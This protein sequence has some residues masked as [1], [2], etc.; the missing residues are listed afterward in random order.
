M[1]RQ[2]DYDKMTDRAEVEAEA[3]CHAEEAGVAVW[4]IA[5]P[6]G[7]W[8]YSDFPPQDAGGQMI[9]PPARPIAANVEA[10]HRDLVDIVLKW[11]AQGEVMRNDRPGSYMLGRARAA[12]PV[13]SQII[14]GAWFIVSWQ[15]VW[16]MRANGLLAEH[17]QGTGYDY[18]VLTLTR[19]GWEAAYAAHPWLAVEASWL[20]PEATR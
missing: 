16:T 8:G 18:P 6:G 12:L 2:L 15:V 10:R 4:L 20:A 9:L 19:R 3:R 13:G 14:L 11:L 7:N 5:E 1:I 17:N